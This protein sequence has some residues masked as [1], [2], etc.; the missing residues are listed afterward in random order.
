MK[1]V[2]VSG[3][4]LVTL[5]IATDTID[6]VVTDQFGKSATGTRTVIVYAVLQ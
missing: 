6:Y 4:D 5:W 2:T 1:S 3:S